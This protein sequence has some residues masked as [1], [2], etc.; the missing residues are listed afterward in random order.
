MTFF[1]FCFCYY[2]WLGEGKVFS[3]V[4]TNMVWQFR[5]MIFDSFVFF[6][7]TAVVTCSKKKTFKLF[8]IIS[9][10]FVCVC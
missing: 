7:L 1:L 6:L 9:H 8:F 10:M 4:G 3:V 2:V 5:D